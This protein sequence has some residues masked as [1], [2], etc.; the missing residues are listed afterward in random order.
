MCNYENSNYYMGKEKKLSKEDCSYLALAKSIIK[1][2]KSKM[3][4]GDFNNEA[5]IEAV[6]KEFA[7]KFYRK[8]GGYISQIRKYLNID[9][10]LVAE[11]NLDFQCEKFKIL[12]MFYILKE[13]KPKIRIIELLGKQSMENIDSTAIGW[14]TYNCEIVHT[15]KCMLERELSTEYLNNVY[16]LMGIITPIWDKLY[17]KFIDEVDMYSNMGEQYDFEKLIS[18]LQMELEE[19]PETDNYNFAELSPIATLYLRILQNEQIGQIKDVMLINSIQIQSN[20]NVPPDMV[21]EMKALHKVKVEVCDV[22]KYIDTNVDRIAEYVYLKRN[23]SASERRKIQYHKEKVSIIYDFCVRAQRLIDM[24]EISTELFVISCLQAIV[25]DEQ[26]EVFEYIFPGYKKSMNN[27]PRVQ[28]ALKGTE[29]VV[30]ALKC[31]WVR[32]V[33]DHWYAN[34]GRIDV[35]YKEIEVQ[36]LCDNILIRVLSCHTMP[37]M[38]NLNQFYYH[39]IK[40]CL[41]EKF[42]CKPLIEH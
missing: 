33:M 9:L 24:Q 34:L 12:Y 7:V 30:D 20:Y 31:Y 15:V 27:K 41:D 40:T 16:G 14:K 32:K 26:N 10:D 3:K 11:D 25:L 42:A 8:D 4:A 35:R 13:K 21:K 1:L 29:E 39:R 2:D 22:G 19:L 28:G 36:N 37:E 17:R 23:V 5:D 6:A 18:F 38:L